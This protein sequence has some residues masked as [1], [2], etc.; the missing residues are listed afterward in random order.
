[1]LDVIDSEKDKKGKKK[2][3]NDRRRRKKNTPLCGKKG[4]AFV[5]YSVIALREKCINKTTQIPIIYYF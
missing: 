4:Q 3:E 5:I 2:R 1:M